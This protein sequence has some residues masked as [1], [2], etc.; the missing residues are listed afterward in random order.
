VRNLKLYYLLLLVAVPFSSSFAACVSDA[1][2]LCLRDN[3]FELKVDW[4]DEAGNAFTVPDL[5]QSGSGQAQ[6]LS[7]DTGL[8][9]FFAPDNPEI[10][11]KVL[12]GCP[13]NNHYWVFAA[14]PTNMEYRLTVTD[15]ATATVKDYFNPFGTPAA[16]ITDTA[17][18]ATC[19]LLPPPLVVR[20]NAEVTSTATKAI[21]GGTCVADATTLCVQNNRFSIQVDWKAFQANNGVG[22]PVALNDQSGYF[23]FFTAD[24]IEL[25]IK[26]LD[27]E[28]VN[29]HAWV[30]FAALT[31]VAYTVTVTDTVTGEVR[32]Y[33]NPL[34]NV[35][36]AV[37]DNQ[38]FRLRAAARSETI[39]TLHPVA[40][41]LF[42]IALLLMLIR[43]RR[44]TV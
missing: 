30:Y 18:F 42:I 41:S 39:P 25:L 1:T 2:T 26:V 33:S 20:P 24:N 28:A 8:F 6:A 4:R 11:V 32:S 9:S 19:P 40:L 43:H 3:R 36:P 23:W 17:A 16:A 34:G 29:D 14:A 22:T 44:K 10:L 5:N 7:D 12:Q 13:I 37:L 15:T 21:E 35:S 27:G 38:A 31:S